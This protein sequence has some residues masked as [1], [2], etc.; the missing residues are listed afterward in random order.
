MVAIFVVAAVFWATEALPLFATSLLAIAFEVL[1]LAGDGGL[2]DLFPSRATMPAGEPIDASVFLL[3]WGSNVL[4]LFMGGF[5]LAAALT[6]HSIDRAIAAK[7]LRPFTR[8]PMLLI[9]GVLAITA[10]FSM[11]MSNTATAAMMLAIVAPVLRQI[12]PEQRFS[13]GLALAIPFGAN[14]GGIGTPIGTPPNAV[15]FGAINAKQGVFNVSFMEWVMLGAPLALILL[16]GVGL[17]LYLTYR[18]RGKLE[19]TAIEPP[20]RIGARGYLTLAVLG[21][22]I[23]LWLTSSHHGLQSGAVALLAAAALTALGALD[24]DDV[25]AI[26]WHILML[27]WGG[28]ALGEGMGASGLTDLIERVD[29]AEL[30]GG[31]WL[32]AA[33][34][35]AVSVGLS[36]VMSNTATANL[37]VPIALALAVRAAETRGELAILTAFACSFAMAMPVST[38]PNAVAFATGRIPAV[39]LLRLGGLISVVASA[40]LLLGYRLVFGIVLGTS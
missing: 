33:I 22:A 16:V 26:D 17:L 28:L 40:I 1:F 6:K 10:F 13:R 38:P 21:M 18:P 23:A 37:M 19:L 15:A 27:M 31:E 5:L 29:F 30:P 25:S 39:S 12:P 2:A 36:T 7:V 9:F 3:P 4:I 35:V 34:V 14:V 32:I 20:E 24:R 8:S 11:W